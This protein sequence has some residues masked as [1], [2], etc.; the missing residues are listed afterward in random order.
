MQQAVFR[1][2][3]LMVVSL[4]TACDLVDHLISGGSALPPI[5]ASIPVAD[6]GDDFSAEAGSSVLLN[7]S[8]SYADQGGVTHYQWRQVAG[9]AVTFFNDQVARPRFQVP[10]VSEVFSFELVVS[11]SAGE[12][13]AD[14]VDM[15]AYPYSVNLFP[16]QNGE[17]ILGES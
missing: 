2:L 15:V 8:R 3:I 1:I 9:S 7:G 4:L 13:V 17:L 14:R 5:V 16:L 11:N 10:L 6:A 12:S